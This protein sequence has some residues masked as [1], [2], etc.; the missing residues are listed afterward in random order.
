MCKHS[1]LGA[2]LSYDMLWPREM[3]YQ[4]AASRPSLAKTSST[5]SSASE[6]ASYR[7]Y[8]RK[9]WP[10]HIVCLLNVASWTPSKSTCSFPAVAHCCTLNCGVELDDAS[11]FHNAFLPWRFLYFTWKDQGNGRWHLGF[12]NMGDVCLQDRFKRCDMYKII[13]KTPAI[14]VVRNCLKRCPCLSRSL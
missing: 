13:Q 3:T 4:E 14:P 7:T 8:S 12:L 10:N 6:V 1:S 9:Q 2:S 5:S 11:R